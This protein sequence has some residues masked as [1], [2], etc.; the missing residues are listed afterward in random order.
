MKPDEVFESHRSRLRA[1]AYRMLGTRSE[2]EDIV[3]ETWL[4]WHATDPTTVQDVRAYLCR[5]TTYLCLD[6]LRSAR[7]RREHYIGLWLPEPVV[8]G[9]LV[10]FQNSGPDAVLGLRQQLSL[11]FLLA[12]QHLSALERAAFLLHD[13]FDQ[14]F[15]EV[16]HTIGRSSGACRQ[17]ASRAR[18]ELLKQGFDPSDSACLPAP[19]Q[20]PRAQALLDAFAQALASGEVA[21]LAELLAEDVRLLSDGGGVVHALPAP[22]NGRLNVAKALLGFAGSRAHSGHVWQMT[23]AIVNGQPGALVWNRQGGLEQVCAFTLDDQSR[24]QSLYIQRNPQKLT[25]VGADRSRLQ[26]A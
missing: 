11:G 3:Q 9:A 6:L 1:L 7:A 26:A 16:A 22:L 20:R 12:L 18:R 4:R 2:C 23:A 15:E 25:H 5:T 8:D 19:A 14:P 21:R 24:L 13:V 10:D 17:L